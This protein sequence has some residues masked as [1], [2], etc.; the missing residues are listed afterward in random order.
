M[1]GHGQL[2][3]CSCE[4]AAMRCDCSTTSLSMRV[5]RL[6]YH[7]AH[8]DIV[9]MQLAVSPRCLQA[10]KYLF[11]RGAARLICRR[12]ERRVGAAAGKCSRRYGDAAPMADYRKGG[13]ESEEVCREAGGPLPRLSLHC[14]PSH[15]PHASQKRGA[16]VSQL[17][18]CTRAMTQGLP[19]CGR[20]TCRL[21]RTEPGRRKADLE[22]GFAGRQVDGPVTRLWKFFFRPGV[23][24]T[25]RLGLS[26]PMGDVL[27]EARPTGRTPPP[28]LPHSSQ[29]SP[30]APHLEAKNRDGH[31]RS[32]DVSNQRGFQRRRGVRASP[33]RASSLNACNYFPCLGMR[34]T[35]CDVSVL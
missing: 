18:A 17:A 30:S 15:A 7:G 13:K 24:T 10:A 19:A 8:I 23:G 34:G 35:G 2:A 33:M 1:K 12:R 16:T 6:T 29:A 4:E 22:G 32:C 14:M 26:I 28:L 27:D 11:H 25:D 9:V 21:S 31:A 3:R 20:Q 5:N